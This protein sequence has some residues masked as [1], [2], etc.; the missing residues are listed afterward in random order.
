M[1]SDRQ[2]ADV[3]GKL[4]SDGGFTVSPHTGEPITSGISVAPRGNERQVPIA[5]ST[6]G[7][8]AAYHGDN[9][10]RFAKGASLGGWRS[11]DTDFLDTPT[12]YPNTPGGERRS[13]KQMVL[14]GQEASFDLDN[15][16]EK[17]NPFHAEG[18][19]KGGFSGSHEIADIASR[20]REGAEFAMKQPE[21]QAWVGSPGRVRARRSEPGSG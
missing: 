19:R 21:V 11:E 9:A 4:A 20:G 6:S 10:E 13:R 7:A 2:F 18:R 12:V 8:V 16:Q 17:F 5:Q 1:L 3:H 14:A 15:F